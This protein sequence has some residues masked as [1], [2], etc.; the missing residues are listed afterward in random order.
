M[1]PQL[2]SPAPPVNPETEAFWSATTR[3]TLLLKGC[4]A[5][6]VIHWYPR[7]MC[8]A[9]GSF[10]T[11][12]IEASGRGTVYSFTI[13]RRGAPL[14]YAEATPYVVAHV[15]LEEGPRIMSN[16]VDCQPE[17]ISVGDH[18]EVLFHPTGKSS[19][20]PR[21]RP[22]PASPAPAAA[23]DRGAHR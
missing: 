8:P 16:I 9:C 17:R 22:A 15:E 6:H 10:D 4:R 7:S 14:A 18:V 11:E 12:W 20:L 21:F 13:V 2:P 1:S 19:A 3:G 23:G 5:C